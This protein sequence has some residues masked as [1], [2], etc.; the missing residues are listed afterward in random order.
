[1][2]YRK[3]KLSKRGPFWVLTDSEGKVVYRGR[4][5]PDGHEGAFGEYESSQGTPPDSE[6]LKMA[7]I[8]R[9]VLSLDDDNDA[10]WTKSGKPSMKAVEEIVGDKSITR[11]DV[12]AA[13][14]RVRHAS[15]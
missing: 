5:R 11:S 9:A 2:D 4:S 10:H 3:L 8:E 13:S 1:M 7:L 15:N 12:T 14:D 6:E